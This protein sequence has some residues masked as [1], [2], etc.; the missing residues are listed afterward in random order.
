MLKLL[1]FFC[2]KL[3][4]IHISYGNKITV[5]N[6]RNLRSKIRECVPNLVEFSFEVHLL[7]AGG[8]GEVVNAPGLVQRSEHVALDNLNSQQ[9]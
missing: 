5:K 6:L 2:L 1:F 7:V 4:Y 9:C 3:S 8:A